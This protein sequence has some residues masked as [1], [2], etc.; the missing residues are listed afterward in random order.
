MPPFGEDDGVR[1]LLMLPL[2]TAA[3]GNL[4]QLGRGDGILPGDKYTQGEGGGQRKGEGNTVFTF[5]V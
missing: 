4:T 1:G 2:Q 5:S 3:L